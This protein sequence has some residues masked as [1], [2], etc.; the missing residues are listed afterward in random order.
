[1]KKIGDDIK[2]NADTKYT[3]IFNIKEKENEQN[4]YEQYLILTGEDQISKDKGQYPVQKF[5]DTSP[6]HVLELIDQLEQSYGKGF[7]YV[8][9]NMIEEYYMVEE[10]NE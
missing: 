6:D 5:T 1:M 3:G 8:D 4:L 10:V 7:D 2:S 9:Y